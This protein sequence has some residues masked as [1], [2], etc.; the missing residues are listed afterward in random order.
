MLR[1]NRLI[2][3]I[4]TYDESFY[5]DKKI[6]H[7]QKYFDNIFI[8]NLTSQENV[9]DNLKLEEKNEKY[10]IYNLS[11]S[12]DT[13]FDSQIETIFLKIR[14]EIMLFDFYFDDVLFFSRCNEFMDM[15]KFDLDQTS[16]FSFVS[17]SHKKFFWY[18]NLTDDR[19]IQ[20]TIIMEV[21]NLLDP[22]IYLQSVSTMKHNS[23]ILDFRDFELGWSLF[24][25]EKPQTIIRNLNFGLVKLENVDGILTEKKINNL[26][27]NSLPI[28]NEDYKSIRTLNICTV[29]PN[30]RRLFTKNKKTIRPSKNITI[31]LNKE[32]KLNQKSESHVNLKL[33]ENI[34]DHLFYDKKNKE[35]FVYKPHKIFCDENLEDYLL[36]ESKKAIQILN[37]ID[38]D[39]IKIVGK[40]FYIETVWSDVKNSILSDYIK[41]P[42]T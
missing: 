35:L 25:F 15:E 23:D 9:D 39:N 40:S 26:K 32:K 29:N 6:Q 2:S 34:L 5:L 14:Q 12:F 30:I 42:L 37:P 19:F 28:Q 31:Y 3:I 21:S 1:K 11:V 24:G 20:G 36:N 38:E 4:L 18:P 13:P 33:T 41:N 7:D 22:V 10:S 27:K 17:I 16:T 8:F